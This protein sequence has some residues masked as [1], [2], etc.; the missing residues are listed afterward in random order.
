M[1]VIVTGLVACSPT[2][3]VKDLTEGN[4]TEKNDTF[5]IDN[6]AVAVYDRPEFE[7]YYGNCIKEIFITQLSEGLNTDTE[8]IMKYVCAT[9]PKYK[10]KINFK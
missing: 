7:C 3:R 1:L 6:K 10:V 2:I 8:H 5:Y 9:H 4:V